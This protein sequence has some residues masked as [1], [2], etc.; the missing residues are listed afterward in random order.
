MNDGFGR[1]KV[2]LLGWFKSSIEINELRCVADIYVVKDKVK[3]NQA[4]IGLNVL[5]HGKTTINEMG[6]AVKKKVSER[7]GNKSN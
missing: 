7:T 2:K 1:C 5:M 6:I 3:S 4:I